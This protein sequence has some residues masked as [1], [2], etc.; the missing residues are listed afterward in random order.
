[1]IGKNKYIPILEKVALELQALTVLLAERQGKAFGYLNTATGDT[2]LFLLL[3]R[4]YLLGECKGLLFEQSAF[5]CNMKAIHRSFL[6]S[7]HIAS[8]LGLKD[9]VNSNE[10]EVE[11]SISKQYKTIISS[12]KSKIGD[13]SIIQKE[14]TNLETKATKLAPYFNDYLEAVIKKSNFNKEYKQ[15]TRNYFRALSILRNKISHS[16][17][18]LKS[19]EIEDLKKGKLGLVVEA[20]NRLSFSIEFYKPIIIDLIN[21]F[22]KLYS[23][24]SHTPM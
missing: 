3:Q 15:E 7:I 2:T 4:S 13:P 10:H 23:T 19:N 21:F 16:N 18:I 8:E 6:S 5:E 12:I 20:D 14:L 24:G 17:T 22:N 1:M 9:I 11:S